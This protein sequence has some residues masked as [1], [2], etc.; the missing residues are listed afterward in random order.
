MY[1]EDEKNKESDAVVG[2]WYSYYKSI[3]SHVQLYEKDLLVYRVDYNEYT[4]GAHGMYTVSYTH[5]D[6]YK[7]QV[8]N[9]GKKVLNKLKR[10][11][12]EVLNAT[13]AVSYTHLDVYKRQRETDGR[14]RKGIVREKGTLAASRKTPRRRPSVDHGR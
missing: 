3:E 13:S 2:A 6:V 7:R 8:Q 10:K 9:C 11:A 1:A 14:A 4:G 5:R 12:I